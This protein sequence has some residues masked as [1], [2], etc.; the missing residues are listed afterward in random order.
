MDRD[1]G[2][3]AP[4]TY[5]AR[6]IRV[7]PGEL[8]LGLV[9][10]RGGTPRRVMVVHDVFAGAHPTPASPRS[11]GVGVKPRGPA[12]AAKSRGE[13][14]F[15]LGT[16]IGHSRVGSAQLFLRLLLGAA[17]VGPRGYDLKYEGAI[18]QRWVL[19]LEFEVVRAGLGEESLLVGGLGQNGAGKT[20]LG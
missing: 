15:L 9:P 19:L 2:R 17:G 6:A 12:E 7:D 8:K 13:K 18:G 16:S 4:Q 11:V 3:S 5:P 20:E 14:Q 10:G 1:D